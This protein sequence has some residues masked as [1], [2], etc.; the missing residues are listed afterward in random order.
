MILAKDFE[1]FIALLNK[2]EV[3]YMIVGGYAMAFHGKPRYTGD[4]DIWIDVSDKNAEKLLR[5]IDDFGM[6]SLGFEKEDFLQP[7]YISQIGYPPLRIDILNNIDG[8]DFQEAYGNRQKIVE[9]GLEIWYIGLQELLVNKIASG[10]K[11][12]IA[13]AQQI[14]KIIP[15]KDHPAKKK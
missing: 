6:T 1:D 9:G 10:R 15:K 8:V 11:M 4:L 2:H 5:V 14:K 12:D 13:D 3:E 7:G